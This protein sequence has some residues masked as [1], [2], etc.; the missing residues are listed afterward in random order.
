MLHLHISRARF[1]VQD[2]VDKH[3]T[4]TLLSENACTQTP[5][6]TVT[7]TLLAQNV[8]QREV[9]AEELSRVEAQLAALPRGQKLLTRYIQLL[10]HAVLLQG[11]IMS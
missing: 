6:L 8:A 2:A 1:A 3:I 10:A 5:V 7:Q 11:D 4:Y 9:I